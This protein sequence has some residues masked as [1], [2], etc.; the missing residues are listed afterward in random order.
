MRVTGQKGGLN[1]NRFWSARESAKRESDSAVDTKDAGKMFVLVIR[2]TSEFGLWTVNDGRKALGR[3]SP[4]EVLDGQS[5]PEER[6]G[7]LAPIVGMKL[8]KAERLVI[9]IMRLAR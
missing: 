1:D 3:S 7:I 5:S 4:A 8:A 6:A 9:S 2:A